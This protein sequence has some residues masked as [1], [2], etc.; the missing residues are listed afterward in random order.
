MEFLGDQGRDVVIVRNFLT[1]GRPFFIGPQ[2]SVGNMY[3]GP[4]YY[5]LIAIPL[6]VANYNPVGPSIFVAL[7]GVVTVFLIFKISSLWFDRTTAYISA[8]LYSISPTVIKYS[9]FSWNPNVMPFFALLFVFL[10][11]QA[12]VYKKYKLLLL[13]SVCFSMALNSH[14][15]ALLLLLPCGLFWLVNVYQNRNH[16]KTSQELIKY[17]LFSVLIFILFLTPQI[18]FDIK[19]HGQNV[20]SILTFFTHREGT[21]NIKF[22]K[23]I[24]LLWPLFTQINTSLIAGKDVIFGLIISYIFLAALVFSYFSDIK[25]TLSK[26]RPFLFVLSW[27][28]LG[29]IGLGLYKQHIYDHYFGF[30]FPAV[31]ILIGVVISSLI[32]NKLILK[33]CG[34]GMLISIVAYSVTNNPFK[35]NPPSQLKN[36]RL[37][38]DFILSQVN[39]QPFNFALLAK[40]NYDPPYKYF[41]YLN[42]SPIYDLHD[43]MTDQLF[44]VCEPW[45]MDCN[46]IN[47]PQWE[48]AAFGWGKIK[49]HWNKYG[50]EIYQIIHNPSGQQN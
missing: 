32:K 34:L 33:I 40:Q 49:N 39:S 25:H 37:I 16:S 17:T 15:L 3:L 48:V 44:V 45:Q 12:L 18:L 41:F 29:I 6:L 27:Y 10:V 9:N 5:Y 43:K 8:F 30:I 50:V 46:P 31:F 42:H 1:T 23:S 22:Y 7:I 19:H 2:T 26:S 36:V 14:F 21:V 11:Y 35:W 38:D 28:L 13:A 47:N 24:P 20:Q 4:F